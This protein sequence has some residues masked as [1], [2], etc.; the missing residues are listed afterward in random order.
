MYEIQNIVREWLDDQFGSRDAEWIEAGAEDGEF[1]S[2]MEDLAESIA[3]DV[4][5]DLQTMVEDNLHNFHLYYAENEV[6]NAYEE[7]V[8][9]NEVEEE[10]VEV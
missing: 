6:E 9:N 5:S 3:G 7:V 8:A 2:F 4:E 10:E 1:E